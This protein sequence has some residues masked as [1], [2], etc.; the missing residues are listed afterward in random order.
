MPP[1]VERTALDLVWTRTTIWI[2]A[3]VGGLG[4]LLLSLSVG[5]RA[6]EVF[7]P[8]AAVANA[9]FA[10][11][12]VIGFLF[13]VPRAQAAPATGSTVPVQR[14]Q[15]E[16]NTNLVEI[17]DWLT[18]VLVGAS[19]TQV[20]LILDSLRR[21]AL[22]V[23]ASTGGLIGEAAAWAIMVHFGATGFFAG[24]LLTALFLG[25]ALSRASAQGRDVAEAKRL[26]VQADPAV[27]PQPSD[28]AAQQAA[29]RLQKVE[30][31]A[32]VG[33]ETLEA[34]ARAQMAAG[35]F[36][37]AAQGFAAALRERP[38]DLGLRRR[39]AAALAARGD[40]DAAIRELE[41]IRHRLTDTAPAD[42]R[43]DVAADLMFSY[44]Y[45]NPPEGFTRAIQIG[46]EYLDDTR[47]PRDA[48]I[49]A[50]LAAACGQQ[51]LWQKTQEADP[52][53][54]QEIGNN[55]LKAA[56]EAIQLDPAWK[57]LLR[58]LFE[59]RDP[60]EN[61]LAIFNIAGDPFRERFQQLLV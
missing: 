12:A 35:Q 23:V 10:V 39:Y 32:L 37:A 45:R 29:K 60:Q 61:D 51:Y 58:D 50:Y 42:L 28:P 15:F 43:K 21:S 22:A 34:W 25:G 31:S 57:S 46:R 8:C 2:L 44:L 1:G 14:L 36:D 24:Y 26:P 4:L 13:A 48:R 30:F 6:L 56:A 59:G 33:S 5:G 54:L 17:S 52:N 11:G 49:Y 53:V 19:L 7:G 38:E 3:A 27:P 41:D 40:Y 18:K 47:N 9:S 20:K 16:H 55:A